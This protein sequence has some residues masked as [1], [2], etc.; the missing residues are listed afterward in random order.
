MPD[1]CQGR[2]L[3]VCDEKRIEDIFGLNLRAVANYA[4]VLLKLKR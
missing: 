2:H 4:A 1:K 3:A